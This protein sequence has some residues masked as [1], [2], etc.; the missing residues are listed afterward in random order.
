MDSKS[1]S[2]SWQDYTIRDKILLSSSIA[3]F[4]IFAFSLIFIFDAVLTG[5]FDSNFITSTEV[6]GELTLNNNQ[7]S[8]LSVDSDFCKIGVIY[9]INP[10]MLL[11]STVSLG[12]F[13]FFSTKSEEAVSKM[14]LNES[15]ST[16]KS[17]SLFS[18]TQYIHLV[19]FIILIIFFFLV[20]TG[21]SSYG[22]YY[23][24]GEGSYVSKIKVECWNNVD[25]LT[26]SC[27]PDFWFHNNIAPGVRSVDFS[28]SDSINPIS[29]L[30]LP[31]VLTTLALAYYSRTKSIKESLRDEWDNL[32]IKTHDSFE[33][34]Y[35][36][37]AYFVRKRGIEDVIETGTK[38]KSG[39][40][41]PIVQKHVFLLITIVGGMFGLDK[42][43]K[44]DYALAVL[45]LL[46]LG[47]LWIWQIYDI[48]VAAGEAGSSWSL[49]SDSSLTT[50]KHVILITAIVG[51]HIGLDRAYKGDGVTGVFKLLTLGG[52][53]IWWLVDVYVAAK[54]AGKSW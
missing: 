47:G 39:E 42:A 49:D 45:K 32:E 10:I 1:F 18:V 8:P 2:E 43:Y 23:T 9:G 50:E 35:A 38:S 20:G 31:N 30:F 24:V 53:G 46:T 16:T 12:I 25:F 26:A 52:L 3:P 48:Y 29:Y 33:E 21:M 19:S 37:N 17:T 36:E 40:S 15:K 27:Q 54:E 51:G 14:F 28:N 7:G 44:G 5:G 4:L 11:L 34:Y 22:E 13:A 41:S 6:C